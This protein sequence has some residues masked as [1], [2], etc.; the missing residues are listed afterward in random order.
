[1][2]ARIAGVVGNA[3]GNIVEVYHQRMSFD[4]PVKRADIDVV[5]E[6]RDRPHVER[7]VRDLDLAGFDCEVLTDL[8]A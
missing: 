3:G 5:V 4:L 2:L 8:G 6:T 1:V 7:I